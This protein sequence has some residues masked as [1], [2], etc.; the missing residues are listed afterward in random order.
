MA[1]FDG[2]FAVGCWP[3]VVDV[4]EMQ[5]HSEGTDPVVVT[6]ADFAC[7]V[8]NCLDSELHS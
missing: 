3:A 4:V 1:D 2:E 8:A 7:A 6:L 5:L